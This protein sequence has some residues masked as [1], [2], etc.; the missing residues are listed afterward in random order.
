MNKID[1]NLLEIIISGYTEY[2]FEPKYKENLILENIT[3][4][5][6]NNFNKHTFYLVYKKLS[7]F[8]INHKILN[9]LESTKK[10]IKLFNM[11]KNLYDLKNLSKTNNWAT[12][13]FY[14]NLKES[15][16][17]KSPALEILLSMVVAV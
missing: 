2:S 9:D 17:I 6:N 1:F 4:C 16:G 8:F 11:W 15:K 12:I 5:I 7:E 10:F 3:K 14:P 13:L